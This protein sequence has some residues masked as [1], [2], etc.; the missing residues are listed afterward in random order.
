MEKSWTRVRMPGGRT[1][2]VLLLGDA[3]GAQAAGSP[4]QNAS[5]PAPSRDERVLHRCPACESELVYPTA[6]QE[7]G[8]EHWRIELRCPA[9]EWRGKGVFDQALADSFDEELDR[10]TEALVHDL[11]RLTRANMAE[12]VDRFAEALEADAILP[13]D[14]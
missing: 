2:E 14:F 5:L 9:C 8:K 12:E 10:G 13:M 6:W 7:R 4:A 3:S 11:D 1:I